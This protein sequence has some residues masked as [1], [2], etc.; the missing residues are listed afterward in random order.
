MLCTFAQVF[1][2]RRI[3]SARTKLVDENY[4]SDNSQDATIPGR[5]TFRAERVVS[6]RPRPVRCHWRFSSAVGQPE[7]LNG[8]RANHRRDVWKC[9]ERV[10]R[11]SDGKIKRTGVRLLPLVAKGCLHIGFLTLRRRLSGAAKGF[12]PPLSKIFLLFSIHPAKAPAMCV[13][14]ADAVFFA[15]LRAEAICCDRCSQLLCWLVSTSI[16]SMWRGMRAKIFGSGRGGRAAMERA[17]IRATSSS[18]RSK[19]QSGRQAAIPAA[20]V[21]ERDRAI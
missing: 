20:S 14:E 6:C 8:R 7:N 2:A 17:S 13:D 4:L 21:R 12:A 10:R 19:S 5:D 1:C 15:T 18:N 11:G 9:G 16:V 3:A